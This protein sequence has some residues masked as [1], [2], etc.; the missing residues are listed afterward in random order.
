LA[1]VALLFM[2]VSA[3]GSGFLVHTLQ[4]S[5]VDADGCFLGL[6]SD[7]GK[8]GDNADDRPIV[9]QDGASAGSKNPHDCSACIICRQFLG[10]L[11]IYRASDPGFLA[12]LSIGR[13]SVSLFFDAYPSREIAPCNVRAPPR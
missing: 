12:R 4:L 5:A 7:G 6:I 8:P 9:L 13:G 10:S 11:K 3:Q 1:A 2:L